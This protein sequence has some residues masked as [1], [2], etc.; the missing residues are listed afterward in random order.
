MTGMDRVPFKVFFFFGVWFVFIL[1]FPLSLSGEEEPQEKPISYPVY[2]A[3]RA[4]TD[5]VLA[6][7][8]GASLDFRVSPG[9]LE[10]CQSSDPADFKIGFEG[11]AYSVLDVT[12]EGNFSIEVQGPSGCRKIRGALETAEGI[13]PFV[14]HYY[15]IVWVVGECAR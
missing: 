8:C 11:G 15:V 3:H 4:Q 9:G 7:G 12:P 13:V 6:G 10:T 2:L 14:R 5:E 1:C